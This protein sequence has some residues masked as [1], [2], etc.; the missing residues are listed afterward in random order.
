MPYLSLNLL[1]KK[2]EILIKKQMFNLVAVMRILYN[3]KSIAFSIDYE[4][5]IEKN[6][7]N[8]RTGENII[9]LDFTLFFLNKQKF[10]DEFN[11]LDFQLSAPE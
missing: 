10:S 7:N 9:M 6:V 5:Y 11:S 3:K 1:H 8:F 2:E 4:K